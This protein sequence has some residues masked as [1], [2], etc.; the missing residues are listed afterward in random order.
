ME[1]TG[2]PFY[3]DWRFW[4]FAIAG[5]ALLLSQLPPVLSWFRRGQLDVEVYSFI[6]L[7]H[8][9]GNPNVQLHL[10]ISNVGARA[11]RVKNVSLEF[12]RAEGGQFSLPAMNYLQNPSDK[13]T[14]LLT[15]FTLKPKEDWGHI[16]NFL[17]VF[18]RQDEREYRRLET[19]LK[20]E[21]IRLGEGI[22]KP[23]RLLEAAPQFYQQLVRSFEQRFRFEPGE[24]TLTLRIA[25]E[26]A[27]AG[28]ERTYRMT[29]FESD[30]AELRRYAEDYKYGAG[31]YWQME[32]H[33]GI[34]VPIHTV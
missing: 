12:S 5:L 34:I 7:T 22:S 21:I 14:I 33:T 20:N 28:V 18:S 25:A 19:A 2:V 11:V 6:H 32:S 27:S 4:S 8:K 1:A 10:I 23:T 26:P 24:Y 29:I 9:V 16:V 3:Q 17:N 31:I 15:S 30:T 13:T